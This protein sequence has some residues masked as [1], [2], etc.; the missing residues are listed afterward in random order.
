VKDTNT[1]STSSRGSRWSSR[2]QYISKLYTMSS[3]IARSEEEERLIS[4]HI[5]VVSSERNFV[6]HHAIVYLIVPQF[7]MIFVRRVP[8]TYTV[9]ISVPVHES[10]LS[11]KRER[12][13]SGESAPVHGEPP[14][15]QS[16]ATKHACTFRHSAYVPFLQLNLASN[17]SSLSCYQFL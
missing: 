14:S 10:R 15:K 4:C 13:V 5:H 2:A 17:R 6:A 16:V 7:D 12:M 3:P 1:H 9:E 11:G 8:I